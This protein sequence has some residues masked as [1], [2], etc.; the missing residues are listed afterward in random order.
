MLLVIIVI[1]IIVFFF[2]PSYSHLLK[3]LAISLKE[4]AAA[5]RGF[6]NVTFDIITILI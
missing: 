2:L 5:S 4:F 3:K 1:V 6:K